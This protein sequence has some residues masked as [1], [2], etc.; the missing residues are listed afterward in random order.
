MIDPALLE[1]AIR[2][3][4]LLST[5]IL[6]LLAWFLR[7]FN[8]RSKTSLPVA[9][10]K[11]GKITESFMKARENVSSCLEASKQPLIDQLHT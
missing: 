4:T 3:P 5:A 9:E 7:V 2:S 1:R 10:L 6:L 8:N 11:D